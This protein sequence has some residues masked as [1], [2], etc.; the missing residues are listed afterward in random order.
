M[1]GG[2]AA[3]D[4]PDAAGPQNGD[5]DHAAILLRNLE[6]MFQSEMLIE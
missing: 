1:G 2:I 3:V 5:P 4:A 6:L